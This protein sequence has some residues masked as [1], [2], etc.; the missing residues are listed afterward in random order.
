VQWAAND[1]DIAIEAAPP[2][3]FRHRFSSRSP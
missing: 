2:A 1:A 3:E